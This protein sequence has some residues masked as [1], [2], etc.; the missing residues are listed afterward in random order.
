M[1]CQRCEVT[2]I[3]DGKTVHVRIFLDRLDKVGA[4]VER[5]CVLYKCPNCA[6]FWELCAYEKAARELNI[7]EVKKYYPDVPS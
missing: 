4:S 2:A 6:T 3:I 1:G 5:S 7:D